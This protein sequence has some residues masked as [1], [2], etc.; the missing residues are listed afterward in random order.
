MQQSIVQIRTV[1]PSCNTWFAP[2]K[3]SQIENRKL[4][5]A[6]G[7]QIGTVRAAAIGKSAGGVRN[8]SQIIL[9]AA[10]FG[11]HYVINHTRNSGHGRA[12][13]GPLGVFRLQRLTTYT[14]WV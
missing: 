5:R 7:F 8:I 2:T 10:L 14:S 9:S 4:F 3:N 6:I 12:Y 1:G 11:Y 13:F